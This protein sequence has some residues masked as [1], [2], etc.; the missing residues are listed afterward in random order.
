LRNASDLL[1][2]AHLLLDAEAYPRAYVL[3]F[4]ALEEISKSQLA[5]DLF[6]GYISRAEFDAAFRR[7]KAKIDRVLWA[8]LW[9]HDRLSELPP[10]AVL[11]DEPTRMA[12]LYVD[13]AGDLSPLE[14]CN[15]V[16][17]TQARELVRSVEAGLD[18]ILQW[19]LMGGPIGTKGFMK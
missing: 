7:H 16:S 11:P 15:R 6:T 18:K 1:R 10:D 19:E 4:T 13:I 8:T 3:A 2:E 17:E 9:V 5:A 12:G 14:P